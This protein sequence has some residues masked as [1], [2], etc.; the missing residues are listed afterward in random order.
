MRLSWKKQAISIKKGEPSSHFE[1]Y[2]DAMCQIETKDERIVDFVRL[3]RSNM[4]ISDTLTSVDIPQGVRNFVSFMF[5]VIKTNEPHVIASAFTFGGE[6]VIPDMFM[7][8]LKRADPNHER[9]NKLAYYLQRH[10][11]LNVD[12]HG[13]LSLQMIKELCGDSDKV[14][15]RLLLIAR[16]SLRMRIELWNSINGLLIN[17]EKQL[18]LQVS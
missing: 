5:Y 17:R 2:L 15:K 9:Y 7:S 8:I 16:E 3:L 4:S 10:I 18:E 6:D 12:D 1:M 14:G 13:L 11:E